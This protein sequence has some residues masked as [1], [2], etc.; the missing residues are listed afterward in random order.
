MTSSPGSAIASTAFMNAMV[1]A[2]RDDDAALRPDGD[3]VLA[4][5]LGLDGVDERGQALDRTVAMVGSDCRR[6]DAPP[7]S[8][9]GGGPYDT[10]PCP[11]DIVPGVS[12]VHLPT[13]GMTGA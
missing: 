10:T 8:P 1:A 4:R 3:A 13:I 6:T 7:R 12:A 9:L 5:E 11:S 2:C